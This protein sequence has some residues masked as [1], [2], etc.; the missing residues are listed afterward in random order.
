MADEPMCVC[1]R[2]LVD[3]TGR[4]VVCGLERFH[5]MPKTPPRPV[6]QTTEE[7]A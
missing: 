6:T 7:A 1:R 5:V 3:L 2:P 4:C